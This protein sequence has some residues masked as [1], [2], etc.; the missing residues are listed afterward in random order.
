MLRSDVSIRKEQKVVECDADPLKEEE[1]EDAN[2][3]GGGGSDDNRVS[4]GDDS[5]D[6]DDDVDG[7]MRRGGVRRW[8]IDDGEPVGGRRT[9]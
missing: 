1:E 5:G 2:P 7:M 8:A 6:E 3:E 4:G 9:G